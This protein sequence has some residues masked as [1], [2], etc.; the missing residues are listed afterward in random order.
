MHEVAGLVLLLTT[1]LVGAVTA[2]AAAAFRL[3]PD[4]RVRRALARALDARPD[5]VLTAPL[6][7]QGLALR[8]GEGRLALSRGAGDRGLVFD[9]DELLGVELI[10]DGVVAA[11]VHR[12][13]PRRPLDLVAP[14][15]RQASLRLVF[16]A[17]ADPVF[18]LE[19]LRPEDEGRKD[20]LLPAVAVA[21]ARRWFARLEAVVRGAGSRPEGTR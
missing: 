2:I 10:F 15:V 6:R 3:E 12:G 20:A 18:E 4:G 16:D 5:A 21:D 8:L 9:F 19:L 7:R 13:E 1:G 14:L 17:V 11:R